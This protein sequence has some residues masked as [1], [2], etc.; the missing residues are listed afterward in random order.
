MHYLANVQKSF[1]DAALDP[2]LRVPEPIKG[3]ARA[4]PERRFAVYR[5]NVAAG[6]V[7]ALA[8]RF[9]VVQ[10]LVGE[11][12]F[13]AMARAYVT[14]DPPRSPVLLQYGATF[15]T[16]VDGFSPAAAIAYLGDVARLEFARGRA[17][18]AADAAPIADADLAAINPTELA[19]MRVTLHPSVSV[20][21][22]RH[23]I[24]SI[25]EAH[26]DPD[27]IVPVQFWDAETA[28]VTRPFHTVDLWR[29]PAG[30]GGFLTGLARGLTIVEAAEAAAGADGRFDL[31]ANIGVLFGARIVTAVAA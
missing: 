24:V 25:W 17:Y 19:G 21:A 30:G 26:R 12:F 3:A 8:E 9:P 28:L 10:R 18:H 5:N 31:T 16:F 1:A 14:Q 2:S 20:V 15:G 27:A 23:P 4:A 7:S 11:E 6:L 29:L 22:S 13:R